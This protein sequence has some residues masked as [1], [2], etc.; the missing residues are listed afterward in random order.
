M[1]Y[2]FSFV[3]KWL[4]DTEAKQSSL[5]STADPV[6]L[7]EDVKEKLSKL[8]REIMYLLNKLKYYRPKPKPTVNTTNTSTTTSDTSETEKT[9]DEEGATEDRRDMKGSPETPPETS[10]EDTE[11]PLEVP[12]GKTGDGDGDGDGDDLTATDKFPTSPVPEDSPNKDT[13]EKEDSTPQEADSAPQEADSTPQEADSTPQEA[14][15]APQEADSTPQEADSTH[16]E[17]VDFIE[18]TEGLVDKDKHGEL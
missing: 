2:S 7:V 3:Q 10:T 16:R 18:P 17:N 15:S 8:D 11:V 9:V 14:D 5:P 6:L 4:N 1:L 13:N 12:P